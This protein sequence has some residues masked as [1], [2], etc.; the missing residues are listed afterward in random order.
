MLLIMKVFCCSTTH[1]HEEDGFAYLAAHRQQKMLR[2]LK[3]ND[4]LRSLVGGLLLQY[5]LGDV[6]L[7]KPLLS[8]LGKPY[9]A[10]TAH[11]NLSHSGDYVLMV[12]ADFP[13]GIDVEKVTPY[14]SGVPQKCFTLQERKWLEAQGTDAAFYAIW[15]AKES[16]MKATGQGFALDCASF[17]V[18]LSVQDANIPCVIE[19]TA[20][21]LRGKN[22]PQHVA[23]LASAC[24]VLDT[25]YNFLSREDVLAKI[26]V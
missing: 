2:Y 17:D 4:R 10:N 20:W 1:W 15:T 19:G 8:P 22:L 12:V 13:V 5:A 26:C 16:L 3:P 11:F 6:A 21:F 18:L 14:S 7:A 25:E 9:Y 23:C 24:E